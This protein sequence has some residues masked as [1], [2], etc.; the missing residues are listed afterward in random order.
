MIGIK[1]HM[2]Y[3]LFPIL[4]CIILKYIDIIIHRLYLCN[5]MTGIFVLNVIGLY[6]F[7][8]N[9]KIDIELYWSIKYE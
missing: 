9:I 5:Y 6:I 1:T 3:A 2:L 8:R 4:I 7:L